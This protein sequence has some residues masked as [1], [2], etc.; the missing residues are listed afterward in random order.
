MCV[1]NIASFEYFV[2]DIG[3]K[4][5]R[6]LTTV[7]EF[8]SGLAWSK[9][10]KYLVLSRA[11]ET[12]QELDELRVSDGAIRKI[13][14]SG[15]GLWPAISGDGTRLAFSVQNSHVNIWRRDL[16]HP[17]APPAQMYASTLEQNAAQYSPDGKR[18]AFDSARSGLWSVWMA[19]TDGSNLVQIS[20]EGPAGFPRWSPDSQNI[21]FQMKDREGLWGIY[22]ANTSDRVPRK[23]SRKVRESSDPTWS[24]DGKWIYFRGYGDVGHQLYRCPA[25]GGDASLLVSS[26]DP[27]QPTESPDA[28]VLYFLSREA[29]A[30]LMMLPLD[31]PTATPQPVPGI[32]NISYGYRWDVAPDGI[33]YIPQSAPRA[34]FFYSFATQ[35]TREI[36]AS[37]REL[38]E[39]ISVSPDGRYL[40][41]SQVDE[42]NSNIMLVNNFH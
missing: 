38:A 10:D 37:D 31:R 16:L 1:H 42:N 41:Y 30:V 36:F 12:G 5:K 11:F 8:P 26:L 15:G 34:L 4:S 9:D 17:N 21:A 14:L 33:Y 3:G 20:H 23:F 25:Q 35:R 29:D 32:P 40:L 22:I 28:K 13:A 27:I 18:V 6:S 39:G 7:R 24:H 19:D 2:T